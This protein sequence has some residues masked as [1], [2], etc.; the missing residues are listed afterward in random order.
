[1]RKFAIVFAIVAT[2]TSN[3][4]FAQTHNTGAGAQAGTSSASTFAGSIGL[5]VL[6]AIGVMIGSAAEASSH[7]PPSFSHSH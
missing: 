4:A 7:S 3:G 5:G 6:A 1:M 2:L